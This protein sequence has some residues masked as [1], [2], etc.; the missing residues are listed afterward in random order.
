MPAV[1]PQL[2]LFPFTKLAYKKSGKSG[3][4]S[5]LEKFE[6][7]LRKLLWRELPAIELKVKLEL[8]TISHCMLLEAAQKKQHRFFVLAVGNILK[9]FQA[10]MPIWWF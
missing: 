1:N 7:G 2:F 5:E 8:P 10:G 9:Q 6:F 3:E 4:V